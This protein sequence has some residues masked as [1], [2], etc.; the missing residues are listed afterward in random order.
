MK[1]LFKRSKINTALMSVLSLILG[2]ILILWPVSSTMFLCVIAGW[3]LL[4]GGIFL[5][6]L[7]FAGKNNTNSTKLL[8]G[9]VGVAFGLWIVLRPSL[10]V[11]FLSVLFGGVLLMRG[12][13]GLEDSFVLNRAKNTYWWVYTILA[14][15]SILFGLFVI[16]APVSIVAITIVAGV[17]LVFDGVSSFI[18]G[19]QILKLKTDEN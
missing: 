6:G 5:L 11:Q 18:T 13:I 15:A 14:M 17:A 2:L 1:K 19:L 3:V 9:V 4:L 10:I 8:L 12:F 7:H 16:W